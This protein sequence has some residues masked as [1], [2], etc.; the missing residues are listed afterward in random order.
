MLRP[1]CRRT[2]SRFLKSNFSP[3]NTFHFRTEFST[4][5]EYLEFASELNEFISN[6][7]IEEYRI[8]TSGLYADIIKR[9]A[10]EVGDLDRHGAEIKSTINEINRDFKENNFAGVI[11]EIELR[12]VESSDRLMQQLI[13]IKKFDDDYGFDI[14]NLNLFSTEESLNK[15]NDQAVGLLMSLVEMMD[16]ERKRERITLSDTFKLEFKVRENDNDTNWV[17][18]LSNVGSDGTDILVK[19][20]VNI[21]LINVFKRKISKRFGDFRLHCMMDEIGKLHPDNV[22]G[23]LRFANVR[24]IFLINSSPTTY[25]AQVYKYTYSLSKDDRSNTVVRTLLTIR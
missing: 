24:N 17:E 13:N 23:I 7:K 2:G 10:R 18:K 1:E 20:M 25:N 4:D 22:E 12:A 14:G 5:N 21:M 9:I 15:T 16:I 6:N 19:S 11:K 8:R 3:Q